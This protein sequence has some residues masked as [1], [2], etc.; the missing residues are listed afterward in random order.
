MPIV[1]SLGALKKLNSDTGFSIPN[2]WWIMTLAG[3]GA[4]K[5]FVS[6]DGYF[7]VSNSTTT[8]KFTIYAQLISIN[9]YSV[10]SINTSVG[11]GYNIPAGYANSG[12]TAYIYLPS[13]IGK[14]SSGA[15][16][17]PRTILAVEVD[18]SNNT[19]V[20][21][22]GDNISGVKQGGALT[23][24]NNAGT[25]TMSRYIYPTATN[26]G[27]QIFLYDIAVSGNIYACGY[28]FIN[29]DGTNTL[30]TGFITAYSSGGTVQWTR[31][32]STPIKVR[33]WKILVIGSTF[34][35]AGTG[36][37]SGD[38]NSIY[39]MYGSIST[40]VITA[41]K[42]ITG[43][44]GVSIVALTTDSNQSSGNVIVGFN[45]GHVMSF[46]S[47]LSNNWIRTTDIG[48]TNVVC[49]TQDMY[50]IGSNAILK[51]PQ[52]GTIKNGGSYTIG[53]STYTYSTPLFITIA[54][55]TV[56]STAYT[57]F[58]VTNSIT[59]QSTGTGQIT[60]NTAAVVT[61]SWSA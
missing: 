19:Y 49:D 10:N 51:T 9:S 46:T 7:W 28:Y 26:V 5:A 40:G 2:R 25:V 60:S 6:Q 27:H 35:V 34:Y 39:L 38:T 42:K 41:S 11:A 13:G 21:Y 36:I 22:N 61:N 37:T 31:D 45:N 59:G 14:Y 1:N 56:A 54:N 55:S 58:T 33:A 43:M 3:S 29:L 16:L 32:F 44:T 18:S 52:D 50:L 23:V 30:F 48:L 8:F 17:G 15:A 4:T 12:T 57:G 53:G 24:F 47:T 20:T